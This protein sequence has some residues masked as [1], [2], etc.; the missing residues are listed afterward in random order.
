[1]ADVPLCM[2]VSV[3]VHWAEEQRTLLRIVRDRLEPRY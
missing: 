2:V 3:L 1:M